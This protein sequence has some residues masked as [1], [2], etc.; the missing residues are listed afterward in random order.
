M[1]Q[2]TTRNVLT[3]IVAQAMQRTH[4]RGNAYGLIR[5]GRLPDDDGASTTTPKLIDESCLLAGD[6]A[7][8]SNPLAA[9]PADAPPPPLAPLA[10]AVAA[11]V[12]CAG[13]ST[14]KEQT[15]AR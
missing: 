7:V 12:A 6:D 2:C 5:A 13:E 8:R 11:A 9:T 14:V 3:D 15:A 10:G 4:M 1:K